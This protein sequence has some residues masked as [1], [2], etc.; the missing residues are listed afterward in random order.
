MIR[1]LLLDVEGT[2]TPIDFVTRVLF[3]FARRRLRAFLDARAGDPALAG[4]LAL[5]RSDHAAERSRGESPPS[6]DDPA[7]LA[8][9]LMDRDRKATGLKALQG[10]I[11]E[12]GYRSGELR[13]VVY[14]DVPP[15]LARW[16]RD[17]R[18]I[19]IY[20]SGSILAQRLLFA[21]TAHGDLTPQID[22]YFDTTSGSKKESSSYRRIA[23]DLGLDPASMLF[24]SDVPQELEA[25]RAAG[26][27]T[28]LSLRPGNAPC[29]PGPHPALRDFAEVQV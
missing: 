23:G 26:F 3:P 25:A 11:W 29:D 4:D 16:R 18:R 27:R 10:R 15:A 9:W 20:S 6:P 5:L 13:S 12:E 7:A 8:E 17:G 2:T 22:A 21:H 24:L 14:D 28:G 1:A 19:A